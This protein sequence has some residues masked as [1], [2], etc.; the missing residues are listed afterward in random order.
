[1]LNFLPRHYELSKTDSK[2]IGGRWVDVDELFNDKGGMQ[3]GADRGIEDVE[4]SAVD[5]LMKKRFDFVR[6]RLHTISSWNRTQGQETPTAQA[7]ATYTSSLYDL[8]GFRKRFQNNEDSNTGSHPEY[9]IDPITNRKVFKNKSN[10][11][12]ETGRKP[13]EIPVNTFRGYRSQFEV[14]R[15]PPENRPESSRNHGKENDRRRVPINSDQVDTS[16][17][18][19]DPAKGYEQ[20]DR[21]VDY[22][23]GQFYDPSSINTL[24][25]DPVQKGLKDYDDQISRGQDAAKSWTEAESPET[26]DPVQEG[27]KEYD[28]KVNYASG[29]FYTPSACKSIDYSHPDQCG[30]REYDVKISSGDTVTLNEDLVS[31]GKGAFTSKADGKA[32]KP[33]QK[34]GWEQYDNEVDYKSGKSHFVDGSYFQ[35][36]P[37]LLLDNC[38]A[39]LDRITCSVKCQKNND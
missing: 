20:Y 30:L 37:S 3:K 33:L 1:M 29:E 19:Y 8:E 15:P 4:Q 2:V 6:S 14:M 32:P 16:K 38:A 36:Q 11:S 7:K 9:E 10:D 17:K 18:V 35:S 24:H 22:K 28:S 21:Q 27:L 25:L 31:S 26:V 39:K 13:I 12:A 5:N 23:S 34:D